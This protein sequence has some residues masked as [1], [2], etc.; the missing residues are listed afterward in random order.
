MRLEC[1][2]HE[3]LTL[4]LLMLRRLMKNRKQPKKAKAETRKLKIY[5][6]EKFHRFSIVSVPKK[7]VGSL[8]INKST[9]I[10][11]FSWKL[12]TWTRSTSQLW[13]IS[14][15]KAG[16][17]RDLIISS[18][19]SETSS[20]GIR[21]IYIKWRNFFVHYFSNRKRC[22]HFDFEKAATR[23][24][25]IRKIEEN[26]NFLKSNRMRNWSTRKI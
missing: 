9:M 14:R 13:R 7:F 2:I 4:P 18:S 25:K 17:V 24:W 20:S 26:L 5:F 11:D 19:W 16:N 12:T 10:Y 3:Y 8:K 1:F 21:E 15:S 6:Q 22:W 23:K